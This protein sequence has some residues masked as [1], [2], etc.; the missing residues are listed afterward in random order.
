MVKAYLGLG[1]NIGNRELQLNE[2]IKI[3][4]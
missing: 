3:L 1:S 4:H 2:A